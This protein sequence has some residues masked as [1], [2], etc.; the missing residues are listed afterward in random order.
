MEE[1]LFELQFSPYF[2]REVEH[3]AREG[4]YEDCVYN[5]KNGQEYFMFYGNGCSLHFYENGMLVENRTPYSVENNLQKFT[6]YNNDGNIV[7]EI[8]NYESNKDFTKSFTSTKATHTL[9]VMV[10][11]HHIIVEEK[12][13]DGMIIRSTAYDIK[14]GSAV[15][16]EKS[17]NVQLSFDI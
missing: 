11:K 16:L 4:V 7:C 14:T 1:R 9:N 10:Y 5:T 3:D 2:K 13:F 8:N 15:E 12:T 17:R 6:F